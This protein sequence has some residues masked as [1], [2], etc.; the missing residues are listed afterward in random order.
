MAFI[1]ASATAV[2]SRSSRLAGKPSGSTAP[3]TRC[4]ASRSLPGSL[5]TLEGV[6][7]DALRWRLRPLVVRSA[8]SRCLRSRSSVTSVM[9]S[10]CSQ[11]AR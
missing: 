11:P 9:S 4:I 6:Q 2:L 8:P 7:P 10:S 5:G 1:V 3:A